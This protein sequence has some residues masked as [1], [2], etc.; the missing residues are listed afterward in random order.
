MLQARGE[1]VCV[2][3]HAE[4]LFT[5]PIPCPCMQCINLIKAYMGFSCFSIFFVLSGLITLE[6]LQKCLAVPLDVITFVLV[7]SNL[8][9]VGALTL[10]FLPAPLSMRQGYLIWAAVAT[11]FV[12]SWL[13]PWTCWVLLAAMACYDVVAVLG[14]GAREVASCSQSAGRGPNRWLPCRRPPQDASGAGG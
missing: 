9:S 7:Q 1:R 3:L 5:F 14:P 6:L 8:A 13:P 11:A 4:A 10:F 2:E 12:F